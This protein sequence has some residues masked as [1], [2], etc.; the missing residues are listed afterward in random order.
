MT[1]SGS[2]ASTTTATTTTTTR[3]VL[4]DI[5]A[6]IARGGRHVLGFVGAPGAG[7]S[8]LVEALHAAR[9]QATCIVPMDGFH[10]AQSSLERLGRAARK[11]ASDTFDAEGY[12]RLLERIRAQRPDDAP[13]WA[14]AFDRDLEDAIAASIEISADVPIVLTEGN[15]LLLDD[16]PWRDVGGLLDACWYVDVDPALRLERLIARHIA[17][18]RA[19]DEARAW[20]ASTDEPNALRIEATRHRATS[21]VRIDEPPAH[22]HR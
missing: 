3:D 1:D 2:T 11:G 18:G 10:L 20:V 4:A 6:R 7:K 16:G 8:T 22:P 15:Y 5:D 21:I 14:P 12:V 19:P 17:H 9:P 13:I